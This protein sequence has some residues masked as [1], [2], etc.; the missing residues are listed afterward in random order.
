MN[1]HQTD[2]Q[3]PVL[4]EKVSS[5]AATA[6]IAGKMPALQREWHPRRLIHPRLQRREESLPR[7]RH[8][9]QQEM[10]QPALEHRL[11]SL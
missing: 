11:P 9:T 8:R 4:K 7:G 3:A 5:L 1:S 6:A 10:Q 2:S